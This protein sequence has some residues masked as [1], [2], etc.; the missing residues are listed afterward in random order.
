[1]PAR[2]YAAARPRG[3]RIIIN[4]GTDPGPLGLGPWI[5]VVCPRNPEKGLAGERD[6]RRDHKNVRVG[7]SGPYPSPE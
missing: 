3:L 1:M 5:L 4:S 2:P 6:S 7:P